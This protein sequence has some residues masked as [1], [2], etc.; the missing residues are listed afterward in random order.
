MQCRLEA[1]TGCMPQHRCLQ[2]LGKHLP[3]LSRA[4]R[5]ASLEKLLLLLLLLS[6]HFSTFI[7]LA[8]NDRAVR[9]CN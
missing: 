7:H 5:G 2:H 4:S 9:D 1:A 8:T 3:Q 6:I